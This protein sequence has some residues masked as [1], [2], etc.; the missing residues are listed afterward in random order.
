[1]TNKKTAVSYFDVAQRAEAVAK[2]I[3]K[4]WKEQANKRNLK[5]YPIPRAGH[6]AAL[7]IRQALEKECIVADIVLEPKIADFAV[8]DI[9]DSGLTSQRMY[10]TYN[11]YTYALYDRLESA[12]DKELGWIIFPWEGGEV[13]G[14]DDNIVRILQHIGDDPKRQGLIETP[15]RFAK[16]LGKWFEGYEQDPSEV[17]KVFEDGAEHY[18][19]MIVVKDIPI[20]SHCEH[21]IA[22]IFGSATIGYIPDG[23][24]VGLSKL[25]RVAD[26]FARRLQVQERLTAQIANA[27]H[28]YLKPKGVGV[29]IKA[30]HMCME[31]RGICKQGHETVTAS[32]TGVIKNDPMARGEFLSLTR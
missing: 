6:F 18:D 24:I 15:A 31:S 2:Q 23:K 7:A 16:A 25:S 27:I 10:L 20:Y 30:R 1:M 4:T 14:I 17:F 12:L 8:D 13:G 19:Q 3:A 9:I 28:T 26:I 22:P 29:V 11:I 32:L 21:H 5:I